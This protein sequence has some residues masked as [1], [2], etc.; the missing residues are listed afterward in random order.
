MRKTFGGGQLTQNGLPKSMMHFVGQYVCC[1]SGDSGDIKPWSSSGSE[2]FAGDLQD[3]T[4]LP[5]SIVGKAAEES[6]LA[7]VRLLKTAFG[8]RVEK[9]TAK[10]K[11]LEQDGQSTIGIRMASK[12][13]DTYL[14]AKWLDTTFLDDADKPIK[15]LALES[16]GCVWLFYMTQYA[17]WHGSTDMP[18]AGVGCF[19]LALTGTS[20]ILT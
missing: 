14:D 6:D 8:I 18:W 10:L 5:E 4:F 12:A 7:A 11:A 13:G 1:V 3:V 2:E 17:V 19:A 15:T 16:F 9:A 20:L